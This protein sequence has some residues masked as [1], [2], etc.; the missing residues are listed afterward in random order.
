MKKLFF[1]K[2]YYNLI[3]NLE[4]LHYWQEIKPFLRLN[5]KKYSYFLSIKN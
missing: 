4:R 5:D 3:G 1:M 2:N